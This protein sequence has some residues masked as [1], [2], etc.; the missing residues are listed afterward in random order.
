MQNTDSKRLFFQWGVARSGYKWVTNHAG[1]VLTDGC[2]PSTTPVCDEYDP[3]R[4]SGL[5]LTFAETP[6]T[7][8]GIRIFANQ[9][10]QIMNAAWFP[11]ENLRGTLFDHW[12]ASISALKAV[13][14]LWRALV[15]RDSDFLGNAI[16]QDDEHV[17]HINFP[18]LRAL[19]RKDQVADGWNLLQKIING[20]LGKSSPQMLWDDKNKL[21]LHVVPEDLRS[22]LWLQFAGAVTGNMAFRQC[23]AC[24]T[25][26]ELTPGINRRDRKYCSNSCRTADCRRRKRAA[27]TKT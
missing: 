9:Y 15:D 14:M 8:D 21:R 12:V 25:F 16:N 11:K 10:G 6:I 23:E 22:A 17:W 2:H 3:M 24:G 20:R 4:Q 5:F 27:Q 19:T 26:F 1:R 18:D 13:A 7:E